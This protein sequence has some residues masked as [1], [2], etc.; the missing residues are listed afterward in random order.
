MSEQ[1]KE[2]QQTEEEQRQAED[3]GEARRHWEAME[4]DEAWRNAHPVPEFSFG[5]RSALKDGIKSFLKDLKGL[6]G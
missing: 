6:F 2:Q 3:A 5:I 1:N 4:N